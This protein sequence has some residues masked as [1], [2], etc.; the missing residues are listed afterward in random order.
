VKILCQQF[1]TQVTGI[2]SSYVNVL[3]EK[4]RANP[5]TNWKAKDTAIFLVIALAVKSI[6]QNVRK[7]RSPLFFFLSMSTK[8]SL[9]FFVFIFNFS[10]ERQP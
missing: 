3:L 6:V 1:E 4:Y 10:K 5:R 8:K 7:K 2:F 9:P